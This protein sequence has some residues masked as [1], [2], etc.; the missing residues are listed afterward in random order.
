MAFIP[1]RETSRV[2]WGKDVEG[3][4]NPDR[5]DIQL[6]CLLRI[7]DATEAMAKNH[8]R[9]QNDLDYYKR[10]YNEEIEARRR[11]ARQV[12]ALRGVITKLKKKAAK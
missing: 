7:A 5:D 11:L 9:L 12:N 2:N 8:V 4:N 1:H 10:A 6:G 3:K